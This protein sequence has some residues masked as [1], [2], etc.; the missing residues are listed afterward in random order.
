MKKTLLKIFCV[1]VIA[2]VFFFG[3]NAVVHTTS[4]NEFCSVC[5]EWMKPMVQAYA[6]DVHGGAN[7]FGVSAQCVDCHLPQDS[8]VKYVFQK[9][10]N[11]ASE[12][13]HMVFNDAKDAKWQ[14][15]RAN[16]E[17]FVYNSGCVKCHTNILELNSTNQNMLD[18]HKIYI[19]KNNLKKD[20][21][22]CVS[23]H[24][25][26]GHKNLGKVLFE[27]KNPPVGD[28]E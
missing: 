13:S 3:T 26:V 14:E 16:R 21:V 18:M 17:K 23:C 1:L 10:I 27:I 2:F 20:S 15:N 25:T 9:A 4:K 24:K 11:G 8:Y 5:H 6:K 7:K 19:E 22:S 12:I 28:W